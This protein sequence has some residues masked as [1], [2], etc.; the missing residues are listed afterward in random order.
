MLGVVNSVVNTGTVGMADKTPVYFRLGGIGS[1]ALKMDGKD[2]G[3][4]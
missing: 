1:G 3:S 4:G 2:V